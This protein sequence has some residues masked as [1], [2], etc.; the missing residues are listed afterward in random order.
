M[1]GPTSKDVLRDEA[2]GPVLHGLLRIVRHAHRRVARKKRNTRMIKPNRKTRG[3]PSVGER[4]T[5]RRRI[6]RARREVMHRDSRS[7]PAFLYDV[8]EGMLPGDAVVFR[9]TRIIA[10]E[11]GAECFFEFV[12]P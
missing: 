9:G 6:R 3:E 11:A 5:S 10:H 1:D 7:I 2:T 4:S 12:R 8:L